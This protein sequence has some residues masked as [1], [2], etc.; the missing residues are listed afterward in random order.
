MT[1]QRIHT[2]PCPVAQES[3]TTGIWVWMCIYS[4]ILKTVFE[5]LTLANVDSVPYTTF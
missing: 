1:T 3:H 5:V 4:G 2:I